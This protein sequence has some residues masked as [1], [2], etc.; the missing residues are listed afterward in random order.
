MIRIRV[1]RRDDGLEI[2]AVGH[3]DFDTRGRDIV[4]AS[5]SALV[6]GFL[7]YLKTHT[8]SAAT[9]ERE[10]SPARDRDGSGGR[11][12]SAEDVLPPL[13]EHRIEEGAIWVRTHGM[14]GID[15]AAW[16]VTR[17]G[18]LLIARR[19]PDHVSLSDAL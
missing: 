8:P 1:E 2:S 12:L 7:H 6:F 3:A 4:C 9:Y 19:Y 5:V 17:A 16:M 15:E 14:N 10:A 11:R 18:L 13:V